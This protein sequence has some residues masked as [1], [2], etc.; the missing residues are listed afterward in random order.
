MNALLWLAGMAASNLTGSAEPGL[1]A[2]YNFDEG[3]GSILRDVSGHGRDGRIHGTR[4][5]IVRSFDWDGRERRP[6]VVLARRGHNWNVRLRVRDWS[7]I[8]VV[9]EN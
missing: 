1:L 8:A 3:A 2:H 9:S 4:K 6:G 5:P 7:E